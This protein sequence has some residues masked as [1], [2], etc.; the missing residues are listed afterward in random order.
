M[1]SEI[2]ASG[3]HTVQTAFEQKNNFAIVI[4]SKSFCVSNETFFIFML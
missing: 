3:C 1:K 2:L 4:L